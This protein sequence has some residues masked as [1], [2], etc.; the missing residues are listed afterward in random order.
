M[1][2]SPLLERVIVAVN[3]AGYRIGSLCQYHLEGG[4]YACLVDSDGCVH[5]A[6]GDSPVNAIDR[7]LHKPSGGRLFD[8]DRMEPSMERDG[9]IDL[10]ALGLVKP[11]APF[12]RRV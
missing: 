9:R 12:V 6:S 5:S 11:K 7:A 1:T 3:N 4:W 10:V 2:E 8:R